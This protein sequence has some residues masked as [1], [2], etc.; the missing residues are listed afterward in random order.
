MK[1]TSWDTSYYL[2]VSLGMDIDDVYEI[3]MSLMPGDEDEIRGI[4]DFVK[5]SVIGL[6]KRSLVVGAMLS[7]IIMSKI[8]GDCR[9]VK[10]YGMLSN[11]Y[12]I[13]CDRINKL[14]RKV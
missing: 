7:S 10:K 4:D 12:V 2:G 13:V 11:L 1:M 14:W 9:S 3:S 5:K 6:D 8:N